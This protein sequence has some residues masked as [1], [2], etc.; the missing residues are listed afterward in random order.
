MINQFLQLGECVSEISEDNP[1]KILELV[2]NRTVNN[3]PVV[4]LEINLDNSDLSSKYISANSDNKEIQQIHESLTRY[5]LDYSLGRDGINR[6]DN[7]LTIVKGF[8]IEVKHL[9]EKISKK[10]IK[11][12][13]VKYLIIAQ[14]DLSV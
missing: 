7:F 3:Y 14:K 2:K 4:A 9:N 8:T 5:M 11:R 13:V 1:L 6:V 10:N 12:K